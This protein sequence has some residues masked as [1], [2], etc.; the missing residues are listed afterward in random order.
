MACAGAL[1]LGAL[2]GG[3][4]WVER[5]GLAAGLDAAAGRLSE[6]AAVLTGLTVRNVYVA[7]RSETEA[8]D[9]IA[10]LDVRKGDPIL[11]VDPEEAR[12]R[13]LGLGWVEDATVRRRLPSTLEIAIVERRPLALWQRQGK[14]LLIDR[15]GAPITRNDLS[16]FRELPIVIGEGAPEQAADLLDRLRLQPELAERLHAATF[17]GGRRWSLHFKDGLEVHLPE[18]DLGASLGRLVEL[19]RR[20]GV[21]TMQLRSIDLRQPDRVVVRPRSGG[22]ELHLT[23]G[24]PGEAGKDT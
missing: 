1:A 3:A 17:V 12:E 6:R 21:L 7:G 23:G 16:R 18:G 4:W 2:A 15:K 20:R 19:Q 11:A 8:R 9:L 5:S 13:L 10:A 22:A 24:R 14:L